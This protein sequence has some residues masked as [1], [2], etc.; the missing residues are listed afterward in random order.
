MS[1][2]KPYYERDGIV[3]YHGDA[4]EVLSL[5]EGE[6]RRFQ[7][8]LTDPP[9]GV[10]LGEKSRSGHTSLE[11]QNRGMTRHGNDGYTQFDDTREYVQ[12][13]VVPVVEA[14]RA[15]S[16]RVAV[17]PGTHNTWLYPE[18]EAIMAIHY[19]AGAGRG[20]WRTFN[21]WS[22]VLCYGKSPQHAGSYPNVFTT[23]ESAEA[24]GHPCPKPERLWRTLLARFSRPGDLVLDPFMGS[25]TTLRVAKDLGMSA[26]GIEIEERYCEIA[27]KRLQ[28]AVLPM[29]VAA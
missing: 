15:V 5:L 20:R 13:V 7:T 19:P 23:T 21:C 18:P 12:D 17:T 2:A 11:R 16:D 4:R 27:A 29:E 9:Y 6:G 8:V 26:I 25:G 1:A 28:Q 3:I 22:P 10:S 14:C 24:N